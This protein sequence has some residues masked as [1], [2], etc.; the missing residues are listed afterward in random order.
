M[1]LVDRLPLS[2]RTATGWQPVSAWGAR[3]RVLLVPGLIALLIGLPLL[4]LLLHLATPNVALWQQLWGTILPPMLWNTLVLVLGVAAGTLLIGT[5]C[6]WLVSLYQF[7]GRAWFDRLLLLPLAIPGFVMGFVFMATFDYAGPVQTAW[8]SVFGAAAPFP[9][10]RSA[11]GVIVVM[12]LVLYPY[13][14]LL[15]RAAFREQAAST[16]EAAQVMGLS[17]TQTFFRLVLPLARPSLAAG[18]VLAMMEALT[19]FG[20]V[21]F[22]SYPTL[23]EGVVR[24]WEGRMDRDSAIELAALLLFVALALVL[25]ERAL[26]GSARYYQAGNG[27][28]RRPARQQLTGWRAWSAFGLCLALLLA[29]FI[30]PVGQLAAWAL[31]ELHQQS[32]G[33]WQATFLSYVGNSVSLAGSAAGV[34]VLLALLLAQGVRTAGEQ[35]LPWARWLARFVTLG[36]ALPG[37]VVAVGVLLFLSPIDFRLNDLA[38]DLGLTRPGLILTGTMTGLVYAY[39][40]RFMAVGYNSIDSSLE[41]ITPTMAQAARCLGAGQSRVLW[42]IHAPLMSSG[43]AAGALLVFVDVMKEL[44]ATLLLRPFGMDTLALWAY[45]SAM[46]SFWQQAALPAVTIVLAGLLPVLLLMRVGDGQTVD[47]AT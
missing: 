5:G 6:A 2:Q 42:R 16:F 43:I 15:A 31:L 40:V 28:G 29:A 14:Y 19:D 25:L 36:Y 3:A 7:P 33:G 22:F 47:T 41:K 34:V 17:R 12:T 37:A 39:L 1:N 32:T 10:I 35:G 8:R 44:P 20:T 13:V 27:K 11:G 23:S 26:R 21:R 18:A 9:E 24:V 45:F 30:L 46:E 38:R 4:L